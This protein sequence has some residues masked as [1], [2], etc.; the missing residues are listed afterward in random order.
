MIPFGNASQTT[1]NTKIPIEMAVNYPRKRFISDLRLRERVPY[2]TNTKGN[3][4][5]LP[6][7]LSSYANASPSPANAKTNGPNIFGNAKNKNIAAQNKL[8]QSRDLLCNRKAHQTL[9]IINNLNQASVVRN[10]PELPGNLTI[11]LISL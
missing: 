7:S 4:S 5:W 2:F 10:S 3:P 6:G 9:A 8:Q 1:I 11:I